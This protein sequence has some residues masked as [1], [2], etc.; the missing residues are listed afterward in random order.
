MATQEHKRKVAAQTGL[1]LVVIL[2]I[3]VVVNVLSTGIYKRADMTATERYTL[4]VGS[5]RLVRSLNEPIQLDAYIARGTA[6]LDTFVRDL[7][8]LLK[9]YQRKGGGKFK[10]TLIEANTEELKE[11]AKEAG[12]EPMTFGEAS[13]TSGD[14]ATIAQGYMGLV[15]KYK[16]EKDVIPQ[17]QPSRSDGLEFWITNKI[18]EIRDKAENVKHKVGV[19]TNK[20]ELKLSD[21]NLLPRRG[22]QGS[23]SMQSIL[24]QA[25]PFYTLEE[26]DLK[27]GANAI[28]GE[29]VGLIITQP[30]K[31]FSDKELRRV[32][33]F[34]MKGNK[35][36][37]VIASAVTLKPQDAQMEA[38]L[39]LHNLDKLLR[40]YGIEMKKDA[41]MDFGAQ[42]AI[43]VP[44]Q[45]GGV[46][47]IRHPGIAH[48]VAD[49]RMPEG[50]ALL[51]PKFAGFFRMQELSFP[52]PSSLQLLRDKQ[53]DG[54]E[55]QAVAR[56]TPETSVV[57]TD[58]V[59]MRLKTGWEPKPP[60]EQRIIAATAKGNLRSAFV[61]EKDESIA[62]PERAVAPSR[63]LVISSSQF[64]TNPFAYSGN[65]QEMGG[66]FQMMGS[67][68]GDPTL[69][70][71]ATPYA[72]RYLNN[73]LIAMKNVLDWMTGDSDLIEA[74]A[75]ILAEPNL[76]YASLK[77][78][79]FSAKVDEAESKL[80]DEEYRQSRKALQQKVQW[81]LTLGVPLLFAAI[82]LGRW[83]F[84]ESQKQKRAA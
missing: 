47:S 51:D 29:F 48:V 84:R 11:R 2:A 41:V 27:D 26:L 77:K 39:S 12:L 79:S 52:Y 18:R 59:D 8:D 82:G 60:M 63:L 64:I 57:T 19:I 1:Y 36:L 38:T 25:F 23:P 32:D 66:Q 22:Q 55:L 13:A 50:Q 80:Q 83:R 3:G 73:T 75:K 61:N 53:P 74:S 37:V 10:F 76:T 62:V 21:T 67:V 24:T 6:Q 78:P 49:P 42:F 33:E 35:S 72:Q 17:L 70:A 28:D 15:F 14:Q 4:S 9:E 16:S 40:G 46:T 30:R 81:T 44:T 56:S 45:T 71:I 68:G 20:D 31:D 58:T 65:G 69:Q 54:V 43:L 34:M 7:T 5:G